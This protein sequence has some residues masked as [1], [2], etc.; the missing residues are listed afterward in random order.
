MAAILDDPLE[1]RPQPGFANPFLILA[2]ARHSDIS[3]KL[4]CRMAAPKDH[5]K[6]PLRVAGTENPAACLLSDVGKVAISK[7]QFLQISARSSRGVATEAFSWT[8]LLPT[9]FRTVLTGR[10]CFPPKIAQEGNKNDQKPRKAI[11]LVLSE[12]GK[13]LGATVQ[14]QVS[15]RKAPKTVEP[16]KHRKG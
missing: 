12:K 11:R 4:V 3:A 2:S 9:T 7:S 10:A 5:K 14:E 13:N 16:F 8:I 1:Q 6:R 15:G